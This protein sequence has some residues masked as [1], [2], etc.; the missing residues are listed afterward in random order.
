MA[1]FRT[2]TRIQ[3]IGLFF[4]TAVCAVLGKLWWVQVAQG[5]MYADKIKGNS[6]VTVR[7]PSVRGEIRDRNGIPLVT[8]RASY[9]VDFY[10]QDMVNGYKQAFGAK[11][12]PRRTRQST[13]KGVLQSAEEVDINKVVQDTVMP[14]L[15]ELGF[16]QEYNAATLQTH[17]RNDT[18]VPF[19]FMEDLD[20][21]DMAKLSER[22]LG[23]PG[24]EVAVRPVRQ[25]LFG[26]LGAHLLGYVGPVS[27]DKAEIKED[28]R[29][30]TFYQADV[31]GKNNIEASMDKWLRG[32]PG[33]RYVKRNP[34]GV[35]EGD[36]GVTPPTPGATVYMTIDARIQL[37]AEEALRVAGRGAAVVIDPNNGDVLAM[38]SVPS[39]DPNTFI[40]SIS[41]K[42]WS[43][44]IKDET[45]PL[46]N[47]AILSYAPGSTFKTV[48]ALAGL[49][50]G[51]GKNRYN[52]SGGVTYGNK[53][54]KCWIAEKGG[55]HGTLELTDAI[56]YSCNAFFFQFGNAA[57]IEQ[58]DTVGDM[59]G[60][61]KKTGIELTNEADGVLPGPEWLAQH[62]P[63]DRWSQGYTANTSIG[64]GQVL[65]S[66][67]QMATVAATLANGGICY[68]PRLVSKVVDK[69][70][71]PVVDEKGKPANFG[72]R[73]RTSLLAQGIKPQDIE[74]VRK[75]MWKV[76]NDPGGT[77]GKAK[78]KNVEVAGKT[79]T[80]QFWR[81]GQKDNHTWFIC[82]A[83]YDKPKYAVCIF[84]QGAKSGGGTAAPIAA[85]ILDESLAMERGAFN[86]QVRPLP[87]APGNFTFIANVDYNSRIG[88]APS[89]PASSGSGADE[90]TE[91]ENTA[92]N[93]SGENRNTDRDRTQVAAPNIRAEPDAAGR[94]ARRNA[95][96][97]AALPVEGG[98]DGQQQQ[99]S[100]NSPFMRSMRKFFGRNT[101]AEQAGGDV[102]TTDERDIKRQQRNLTQQRDQLRQ[103]QSSSSTSGS[104][105]Q[106]PP[107]PPPPKKKFLGIF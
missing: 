96:V 25:Y 34:K 17:Y 56:K 42:D 18:L 39:F 59:L 53:Y 46:T 47:R 12:L 20:F 60:L 40:P 74:M 10:L 95:R 66:P 62:Q 2:E 86:P 91:S 51:I 27:T 33:V 43:K 102:P 31:E 22:D 93:A 97:A 38:A 35:I 70:G 92:D 23:L 89:T 69:D 76:V 83:P 78:I 11:N 24:V 81:N 61:G 94:Q 100:G 104:R 41:G 63:K 82:F 9:E 80:A 52:C 88:A 65:C 99:P 75:G 49:R 54:M 15:E 14:R 13:K 72:P 87:P 28:A 58:I 98:S 44:L 84:L 21:V 107:P 19:T 50:A 64:Q 5:K 37:I 71:K 36:I 7:I 48:T 105:Q 1:L 68:Y 30:F 85:R 29:N 79:G 45:N 6:Q 77:A 106:Q 103:R 3:L 8:N 32:Q 16:E 57:K 101:A 67:L 55:S 90:E 73:V 4:L 26:S